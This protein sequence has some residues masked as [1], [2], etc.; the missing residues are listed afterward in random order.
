[1]KNLLE[2]TQEYINL[3][4]SLGYKVRNEAYFLKDFGLFME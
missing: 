2:A 4:R 1:M 3:R